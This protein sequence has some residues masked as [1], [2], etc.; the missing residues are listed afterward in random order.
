M[1]AKEYRD[2]YD[3]MTD[4]E[5]DLMYDLYMTGINHDGHSW[6]TYGDVEKTVGLIIKKRLDVAEKEQTDDL[7]MDSPTRNA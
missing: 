6:V 3:Y 7:Q 5:K 2:I 4:Y 1:S